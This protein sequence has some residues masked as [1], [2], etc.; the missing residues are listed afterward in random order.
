MKLPGFIAEPSVYQPINSYATAV[1]FEATQKGCTV[2]PQRASG[3]GGPIGLPGQ[4]CYGACF[5]LCVTTTGTTDG[6]FFNHCM[7]Q[8]QGTCSAVVSHPVVL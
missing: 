4:D 1:T 7:D 6:P 3:P 2:Y 8:C 5:H